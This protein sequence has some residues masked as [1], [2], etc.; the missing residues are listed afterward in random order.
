[1]RS[2]A[3]SNV[4]ALAC[5][6]ALSG[7]ASKVTQPE[8][9]SG[10]LSSY[11]DLKET[12]SA[13]GQPVLRWVAPGFNDANYDTIVWHPITYYPTPKPTTQTGQ[14]VLD[15]LLNY[16]NASLKTAIAERKP[17]VTTP[18]PRSLIFRGA[19]T[20][21]DTSPKGL[22]FYEV[23]PVALVIAGTQMATGHRSENTHLYFEGELIDAASGRPVVKVVRQ[24]QGK[25]LNN[26]STPLTVESLKEVVDNMATDATMF[27]VNKK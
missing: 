12:T 15:K 21:V 3:L 16:T 26:A 11:S 6:L 8:K 18:G 23:I 25:V 4:A 1:M 7:C 2:H 17:L 27:D 5:L 24:G 19:I 13:S 9:F 22:Q 20:G 10:F 14:Q